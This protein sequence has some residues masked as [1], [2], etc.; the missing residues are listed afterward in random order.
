MQDLDKRGRSESVTHRWPERAREI[1]LRQYRAYDA[2]E[3]GGWDILLL[4][5]LKDIFVELGQ[6][7]ISTNEILAKL[8]MLAERPWLEFPNKKTGDTKPM[9]SNQL[10]YLLKPH[11]IRSKQMKMEGINKH[12][13]ARSDFEDKCAASRS[14]SMSQPVTAHRPP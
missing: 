9:T 1:M 10:A 8:H 3:D 13:Y 5:D 2:T 11:E 6:E 12:G 14:C 4:Q 7:R